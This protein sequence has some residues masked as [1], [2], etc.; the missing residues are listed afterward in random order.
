MLRII[1][2]LYYFWYQNSLINILLIFIS[3]PNEITM[4][5]FMLKRREDFIVNKTSQFSVAGELKNSYAAGMKQDRDEW[6]N[7]CV[8]APC[9]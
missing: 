3:Y 8:T 7:I 6:K 4:L 2:R 5:E 9:L 1:Q